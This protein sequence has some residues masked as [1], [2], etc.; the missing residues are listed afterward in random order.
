MLLVTDQATVVGVGRASHCSVV[1]RVVSHQNY[2]APR[3]ALSSPVPDACAAC[4]PV[5]RLC[6]WHAETLAMRATAA[7]RGAPRALE[8]AVRLLR[9][10]VGRGL[11]TAACGSLSTLACVALA[12]R[13]RRARFL[14]PLVSRHLTQFFVQALPVTT[15]KPGGERSPRGARVSAILPLTILGNVVTADAL[16][17]AASDTVLAYSLRDG[18]IRVLNLE[19]GG[20][21]LLR[22]HTAEISDVQVCNEALLCYGRH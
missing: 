19:T 22:N 7:G 2:H 12:F 21:A 15:L 17:V 10:R 9:V 13:C 20:R 5:T 16:Q 6:V 1:S 14:S 3:S 11:T 8:R 18:L 4:V